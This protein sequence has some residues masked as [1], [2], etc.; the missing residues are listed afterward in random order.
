MRTIDCEQN[1]PE[2]HAARAGRCTGSR[3]ADVTAKT[4]TGVS[5]MRA[6]YLGELVA[7]RLAGFQ[8][9]DGFKSAAMKW[10]TDN[11]ELA[12]ATYGFM[13]DCEP[14]KV[15]FVLHP[16]W[17]DAGASPD[18]LINNDGLIQVKCP[19]SMTHITSLRGGGIDGKY[20]KQ[21][22]WEMRC[23]ERVYC[24]FVSFDPRFPPEMQLHVERVHR[25]DRLIAELEKEVR[26]FLDEVSQTVEELSKKYLTNKEAA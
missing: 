8:G 3:I 9:S 16:V 20:L 17:D 24:D 2:W 19:N 22:Q 21:M 25:D 26:L 14:K 7:E 4:K 12:C 18:R 1:T 6:T 15:G 11:E 10:G 5:A 13:Y 23:A